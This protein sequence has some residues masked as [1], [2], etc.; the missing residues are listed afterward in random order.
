M[1]KINN[2]YSTYVDNE[3][4]NDEAD[5]LALR[6]RNNILGINHS[7]NPMMEFMPKY[8]QSSGI[9][10]NLNYNPSVD[11]NNVKKE[12]GNTPVVKQNDILKE[13]PILRKAIANNNK[14]EI[15]GLLGYGV[16]GLSALR[17]LGEN[18]NQEYSQP[19]NDIYNKR[20][21]YK[22]VD[23]EPYMRNI[24]QSE[25]GYLKYLK[26]TGNGHLIPSL[27]GT[28]TQKNELAAKMTEANNQKELA[29]NSANAQSDLQ[30]QQ[31][32]HQLR[33]EYE[34]LRF[35]EMQYRDNAI[36]SNKTGIFGALAGMLGTSSEARG[37]R[38]KLDIYNKALESGDI[39]TAMSMLYDYAGIDIPKKNEETKTK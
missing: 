32:N 21:E 2:Q 17:D 30:V 20:M 10:Y 27:M 38:L 26:E 33:S 24:E 22:P 19:P 37:N 29:V 31:M 39:N 23:I 34:K 12:V 36:K 25:A 16:Q 4:A 3:I 9:G 11:V 28:A 35:G 13:N 14:E 8:L 5:I 7:S 15:M 1:A 6:H 18:L